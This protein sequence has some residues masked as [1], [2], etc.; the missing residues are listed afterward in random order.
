MI[1]FH[2]RCQQIA[3]EMP[4]FVKMEKCLI[5]STFSSLSGALHHKSD[6]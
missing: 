1:K 4:G 5:P 6:T 3:T 2:K